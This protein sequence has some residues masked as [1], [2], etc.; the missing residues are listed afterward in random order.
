MHQNPLSALLSGLRFRPKDS[1]L[2]CHYLYGKI[3]GTLLPADFSLVRVCNLYG[4][5][6]PWSVWERHGGE[7][8]TRK[9]DLY[10]FTMLKKKNCDDSKRYDRNVGAGRAGT[11]SGEDRGEPFQFRIVNS[12]GDDTGILLQ[13]IKKRFRYEN[14][15]VPE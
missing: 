12:S 9:D 13:A 6:E 11:W 10:F 14:P 15:R 2:F 8:L 1:E 7:S 5:E 4:E 3:N